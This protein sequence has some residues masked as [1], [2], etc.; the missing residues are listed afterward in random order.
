MEDL[1]VGFVAVAGA[2]AT[3][4][5]LLVALTFFMPGLSG[6]IANAEHKM[7][8]RSFVLGTVN[9]LFFF[10][11]AAVLAQIGESVS[12][13]FGG[14]F[15]LLAVTITLFMLSLMSIGLAGLVTLLSERLG[16]EPAPGRTLRAALLLV[17]AGL[18]PIIGWL[19][20]TPLALLTGLGAT[21]I[22]AIQL[23]NRK[24]VNDNES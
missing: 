19:I 6:R 8:V 23:A 18:A 21:I 22:A 3:I 15:T 12:G 20:F 7:P 5:A 4:I 13:A 2:A 17:A 9:F 16:G 14:F 24:L 10:A 1:F 11:V